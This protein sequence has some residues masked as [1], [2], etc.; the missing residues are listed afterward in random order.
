MSLWLLL[1]I[2]AQT[3]TDAAGEPKAGEGRTT[4]IE[5]DDSRRYLLK[6]ILWFNRAVGN[7][8]DSVKGK[9]GAAKSE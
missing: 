9:R 1:L 3:S 8:M 2:Q 6:W 5:R 7:Q 4:S